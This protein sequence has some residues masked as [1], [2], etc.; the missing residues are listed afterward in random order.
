MASPLRT[1][2]IRMVASE[3]QRAEFPHPNVDGSSTNSALCLPDGC[4]V[5]HLLEC[6]Q[7]TYE[8]RIHL[9][10]KCAWFEIGRRTFRNVRFTSVDLQSFKSIDSVK[11][12]WWE[13]FW[14]ERMSRLEERKAF[15]SS[16]EKC[17]EQMHC[18]SFTCHMNLITTIR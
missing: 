2:A 12:L 9:P 15:S 16:S 1:I 4:E 5:L 7:S 6:F 10:A 11:N 14:W 3:W 13:Q 18:Y 8:L 17:Q